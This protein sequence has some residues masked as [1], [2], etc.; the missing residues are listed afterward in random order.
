MKR[1]KQTAGRSSAKAAIPLFYSI[2]KGT[3]ENKSKT[4]EQKEWHSMMP[5][6]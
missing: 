4:V 5:R 3:E 6:M 2:E 1:I